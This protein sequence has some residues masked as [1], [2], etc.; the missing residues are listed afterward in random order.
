MQAKLDQLAHRMRQH[1]DADAERFQL[2]NTLEHADGNADLVQAERQRQSANAAAGDKDG[3]E[4]ALDV[5]HA[6]DTP[7]RPWA[8]AK[9]DNSRVRPARVD[10]GGACR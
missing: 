9:V 5:W 4:R 10:G 7:A 1:V 6:H 8:T 2:G 3:H